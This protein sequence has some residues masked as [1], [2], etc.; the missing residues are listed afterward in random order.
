VNTKF[1]G[2]DPGDE[3]LG[4][5]LGVEALEVA[6]DGSA[7]IIAEPAVVQG[8]GDRG[9]AG[10]CIL[11]RVLQELGD[12]E[13]LDAVV[14][15]DLRELIV[16][17]LGT[18]HP[19]QPVEQEAAAAAR[20]NPFQLRTRTVNKNGTQPAG[21]AVRTMGVAHNSPRPSPAAPAHG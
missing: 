7:E 11:Q 14:P 17:L 15:E 9:A 16:L 2:S 4:Q 10:G 12:V 1:T 8:R 20:G 19:G 18:G 6:A 3:G 21:L 13:H 5:R